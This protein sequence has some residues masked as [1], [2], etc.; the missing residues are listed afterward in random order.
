MN[1]SKNKGKDKGKQVRKAEDYQLT[2]SLS[3]QNQFKPLTNFP[4]LPYKAAVSQPQR[5]IPD[6]SYST[7][8]V[9]HICLTT[10]TTPPPHETLKLL[11]QKIF[12]QKHYATDH[13]QKTQQF[14]ELILVDT[15]SAD[16]SHTHDKNNPNHILFSKCIIRQV[17][18]A[19]QWKDPFAERSFSVPFSP[20]TYNYHDYR[21][22]WHRTFLYRPETHSWFFNFHDSCPLQFPIWFYQWWLWFGSMIAVLPD[23]AQD[24]WDYWIANTPTLDI[25]TKEVQF[26]RI[27]NIAWIFS[28]EYRIEDYLHPPFPL[29]LIRVYKCKWWNEFKI[30]LCSRENVEHYCKHKTKKFTLHN[31]HMSEDNVGPSTP[32][33]KESPSLSTK[34]KHKGLTQKEK[35]VLEYLKDDPPMRQIFLQKIL[36]KTDDSDDDEVSSTASN[37]ARRNDIYQDSQDPYDM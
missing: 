23:K 30:K 32:I 33:K 9:E 31:I 14:Y 15:Q 17:L 34:A 24:G 28:W 22:A 10:H 21:M 2:P 13:T 27:F 18:S 3:L 20:Q 12:G 8:H 37:N 7:H 4:P 35:D 36:A 1:T 29:S 16:I 25:Y 5:T 19:K 6:L 11:V 26:F